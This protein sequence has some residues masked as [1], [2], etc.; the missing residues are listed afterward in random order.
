[1][2]FAT[3]EGEASVEE[4]ADRLFV[5]LTPRQRE[6]ATAELL[7]ANPN[8]ARIR[9]VERG[10]ILNVPDI[11]ALRAK[12]TESGESPDRQVLQLLGASLKSYGERLAE[13]H[14]QDTAGIKAQT[15]IIKSAAFT[16]AIS[17]SEDL[18]AL[19]ADARASLESR[20]KESTARHKALTTALEKAAADIA[21]RTNAKPRPTPGPHRDS[22]P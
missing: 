8:L 17:R 11:P 13:R 12:A 20:A 6:T 22:E 1:M 3:Y 9:N 5:R 7:R 21:N 14:G 4:I 19:A 10:T 2:P 15:A 18:V 16:R